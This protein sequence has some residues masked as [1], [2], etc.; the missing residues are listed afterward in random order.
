MKKL[1]KH[2]L[3]RG[4]CL[5]VLRKLDDNS[6]DSIVTDPPYGLSFMNKKWD[7]DVPSIEIWKEC[8]RVLKPGGHLLAFAGTRTQHRMACRIEDAGFE[9]RDLIAWCYGCLDTATKIATNRGVLGY[10]EL[11]AGDLAI[12]YDIHTQSYS[13]Q[14]ILKVFEYDYCD[15]AFH[16]V[17]DTVTQVVSKNHNCIIEQDGGEVLQRA[18]ALEC[19]ACVPVLED[20]RSLQEALSNTQ[21]YASSEKQNLF[22]KMRQCVDF[23]VK[24]WKAKAFG[25]KKGSCNNLQCVREGNLEAGGLASS[26]SCSDMQQAVQ[27]CSSWERLVEVCSY[28]TLSLVE[29]IRGGTSNSN[30]W[31]IKSSMERWSNL[32]VAK[33]FVWKA[34][35]KVSEVSKEVFENGTNRRLRNGTPSESS[36]SIWS[37]FEKIRMCSS[38]EPRCD[39]QQTAKLD[40]IQNQQRSQVVR[41]WSGHK[42]SLVRIEKHKYHGKVWCVS[43]PTGAFVAVRNGVAFP[44]GNSGFPK[45][46]DVG[47]SLLKNKASK[48]DASQWDGWGTALKPALEP[49]TV[50]RKPFKGTVAANVLEHGT[51]AMNIDGCRVSTSDVVTNH[52]RSA[53]SAKSKGK[54]GDS[55]AQETHQTDGQKS[56]RWPANLIHDG[57]EEVT[58]KFPYSKDGVA[59]GRNKKQGEAS[60]NKVY[61]KREVDTKDVS[62]GGEG[63]AARFFYC[64]KANKKDRD[65]NNQHPTVKPTDLM[66]YLVR[67]VT[68]KKS[69]C[70]DPFM[71]S[72]STGKAC[73]LEGVRFIGIERD[74]SSF[75]TS[76]FRIRKV[77]KAKRATT[78][79]KLHVPK[80]KKLKR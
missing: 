64:A 52:A 22:S 30:D 69:V 50:A 2:R 20:L 49:I 70:L 18:E 54:Y 72:G 3:Y 73:V 62:Y 25:S 65:E 60:G 40:A 8:L 17:G 78:A 63:S 6:V 51:G 48:S 77:R 56:G 43:V 33:R 55:K 7:Y 32:Q 10:T 41:S 53:E 46:Q 76:V 61:G 31:K 29:K 75:R 74:K 59:V 19:E 80:K 9:I 15:T 14:P 28:W 57:S 21:S 66:R 4:D 42:T 67:L 34:A 12:C 16:L 27:R 45:S 11:Q 35:Y 1:G 47:K 39:R 71:G 79:K 37:L 26:S 36:T 38:Q 44:T 23:K 5:K 58:S 13:Y 68:P 24:S